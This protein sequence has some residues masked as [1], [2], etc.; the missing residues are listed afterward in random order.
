MVKVENFLLF[1]MQGIPELSGV[2]ALSMAL[3]R[4]PLRWGRIIAGGTVLAVVVFTIRMFSTTFG[5]HT[6][7]VLLL[8]VILITSATR[9]LPMKAFVVVSISVIMLGA[10]ER[11][12][13]F[14]ILFP[15]GKI[16]PQIV[17]SNYLLW[18]LMAL[19]QASIMIFLALLMPRFIIPEQEQIEPGTRVIRGGRIGH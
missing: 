16:D 5:L 19:P 11:I 10:L 1:L 18:K 2:I 17:T 3:A 14:E 8:T 7:A 9:V 12:I 4:V 15:L 13:I 6:V